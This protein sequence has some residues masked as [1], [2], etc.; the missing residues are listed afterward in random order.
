VLAIAEE[1]YRADA[2]IAL[3]LQLASFGCEMVEQYG[4]D[5]QKEEYLRPV[6]ENDQISGLAVSEPE[7]GPTSRG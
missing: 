3:T 6:A 1:F 7:T 5:E 2:G 4:T